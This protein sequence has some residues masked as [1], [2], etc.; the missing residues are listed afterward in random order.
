MNKLIVEQNIIHLQDEEVVLEIKEKEL[1]INVSGSVYCS[2][3]K[4]NNQ[5]LVIK[6]KENS[7][8]MIEFFGTIEN[9]KNKITI[10]NEENS[11]LNLHYAC[12]YKENNELI[13]ENN[14]RSSYINNEILVRAVEENG[15][16]IIKAVGCIEENTKD[17]VYLEDIKA[18]V[19]EN[20][21]IK[22]MPDLLVRSH[23]VIANHN[24]TISPVS[25]EQLFYLEKK[26]M[27][28][29]KAGTLIKEGFL[30]GIL[31]NK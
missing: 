3:D 11:K 4:F 27:D 30:K 10:Y 6:L 7:H 31:K 23:S 13:I 22:I 20:N 25:E 18:I 9:T 21:S 2:M 1:E 29:K 28:R 5:N 15:N 19:K 12:I 17:N 8:L 16:L 14:I 26:G 24:A